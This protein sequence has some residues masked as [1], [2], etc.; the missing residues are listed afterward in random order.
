MGPMTIVEHVEIETAA[1]KLYPLDQAAKL[2]G[3]TLPA[4]R[5]QVWRGRIHAVALGRRKM[6]SA[7]EI[8][9]IQGLRA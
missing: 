5:A 4:L 3:L 9:R 8:D 1:Q 2:L 7:A 6:V